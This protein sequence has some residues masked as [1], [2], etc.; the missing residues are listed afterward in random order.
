MALIRRTIYIGVVMGLLFF[1]CSSDDSPETSQPADFSGTG[2]IAF[3]GRWVTSGV[4]Y[5]FVDAVV[6]DQDNH[7][8]RE[9]LQIMKWQESAID[10][11]PAGKNRTLVIYGKGGTGQII[12]RSVRKGLSVATGKTTTVASMVETSFIPKSIAPV[13]GTEFNVR[14]FTLEWE[15]VAGA[16]QYRVA[17]SGLFDTYTEETTYSYEETE[18][19]AA[20]VSNGTNSADIYLFPDTGQLKRYDLQSKFSEDNPNLLWS[21]EDSC[22]NKAE[23]QQSYSML[24]IY[25]NPC[26]GRASYIWNVWA[27]DEFGKAS[28][29][30]TESF[31]V[32]C[33]MLKD[34]VTG[35]VWQ[36]KTD[37]D[38]IHDKH[39]RYTWPQAQAC[40]EQLN[41]TK[42]GGSIQPLEWRLPTIK[43]LATIVN[44]HV[45]EPP[46]VIAT[47]FRNMMSYPYWS[48]T[49]Y[50]STGG[51][52]AWILDFESGD[53]GHH[54]KEVPMREPEIYLMAVSGAPQLGDPFV[55]NQDG[56]ITDKISG[57]TWMQPPLPQP[58]EWA[59]ALAFCE[60]LKLWG[61]GDGDYY[62]STMIGGK[63]M[64]FAEGKWQERDKEFFLPGDFSVVNDDWRLPDRNELMSVVDYNRTDPAVDTNYF[65]GV[66]ASDY[67]SSTTVSFTDYTSNAWVVDFRD[68]RI[69]SSDKDDSNNHCLVL[70][71]RDTK[72]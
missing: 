25:G 62:W 9:K 33:A 41:S 35:L 68:G 18:P 15:P 6:Y 28:Q 58:M 7:L 69:T 51:T 64:I 22:Y 17:V 59:A 21:G 24:D 3:S 27:I 40:I 72:Q 44:C 26:G 23:R 30:T 47:Y 49:D 37:D 13:T 4:D 48:S 19:A 53:T 57:L 38:S 63:T 1:S 31:E 36:M 43:D 34:N 29:N 14:A 5:N 50:Q 10:E 67:W 61:N 55:K 54:A 70:P 2:R 16:V 46:T 42:F 65:S 56:T 8:L 12:F 66:T 71:V 32:V 60:Y 52:D 45:F 11:I 20:P 39:N